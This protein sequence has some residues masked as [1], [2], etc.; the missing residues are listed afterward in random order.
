MSPGCSCLQTYPLVHRSRFPKL[1]PPIRS[2]VGPLVRCRSP[3]RLSISGALR[4]PRVGHPA[5]KLLQEGG[6]H[7]IHHYPKCS[8]STTPLL[9]YLRWNAPRCR[10]SDRSCRQWVSL[11]TNMILNCPTSVGPGIKC[12]IASRPGMYTGI[13]SR[14]VSAAISV[15]ET[16]ERTATE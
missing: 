4:L 15:L 8:S 11:V 1:T 7:D 10:R 6:L 16:S 14:F 9:V 12:T 13:S 2:H 5:N 3:R